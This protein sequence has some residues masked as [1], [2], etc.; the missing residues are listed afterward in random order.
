MR[1]AGEVARAILA[2]A[3]QFG[4]GATLSELAEAA[5]V[6]KSAARYTVPNLCRKGGLQI[7]GEKQVEGRNRPVALYAPGE[8]EEIESRAGHGWVDLSRC[9]DG[10]AR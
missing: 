4:S 8:P 2:A 5:S 6:G 9:V 7:V 3:R 1:P 10:W